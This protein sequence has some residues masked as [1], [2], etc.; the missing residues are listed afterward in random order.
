MLTY[1]LRHADSRS[2]LRRQIAEQPPVIGRVILLT[3]ALAE[4]DQADEFALTDQRQRQPDTGPAQGAHT[5][6]VQVQPLE[7]DDAADITLKIFHQG[8]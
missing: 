6:R 2:G 3:P 7:I 1:Q 8:I 5:F 4:I